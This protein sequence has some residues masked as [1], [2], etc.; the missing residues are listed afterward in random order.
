[1]SLRLEREQEII[2]EMN[3]ALEAGQFCIYLQPKYDL[4]KSMLCGA[5]ALVRWIHPEKGMVS[6]GEFIPIFEKNGFIAKLDYY[7][8]EMVCKQLQIWMKQGMQPKPISVN[9]SRVNLCNPQ[10]VD[11]ITELTK[12]YEIPPELF[13]L[14]LTES[15]YMDNPV[16]MK[17]VI[18]KL[19][20]NGFTILMDDFGNGYSSLSILKDMEIDI[21]K[22]DMSFFGDSE[23]P[24]RGENIIASVVRMAKWLNIPSIAEGVERKDQVNFLRGVGCEFVQGY[25]FARPMP[26][27]IGRAHV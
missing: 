22:I 8:W 9:V 24:G 10:I 13:Q 16:V 7:I 12:R 25:Y 17:Q 27:E 6:P 14:E 23:I 2:N 20:S 3:H 21:L 5:E 18:K 1:M 19:R 4:E 15:A 11:R 26:I